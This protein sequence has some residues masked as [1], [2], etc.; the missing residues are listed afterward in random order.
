MLISDVI[1]IKGRRVA[2]L[3]PTDTVERAVRLL[4]EQRIGAVV[5]EDPWQKIVGIFSERDLVRLL[6]QEGPAV[7]QRALAAVMT[8]NVITCRADD[9]IDDILR[10]MTINKVRHVPV[11]EAGRLAG[12]VSIG[13]L[14]NRRLTEKQQEAEVLLEIARM[15]A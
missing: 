2:T 11:T 9:R 15:R 7:L 8:H 6:A 5:V 3:L 1:A 12:I 4:A 13:D 10:L 14:V